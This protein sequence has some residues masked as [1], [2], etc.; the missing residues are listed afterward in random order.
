MEAALLEVLSGECAS[1]RLFR[2]E[3]PGGAHLLFR[4][5]VEAGPFPQPCLSLLPSS[6][7][8]LTSVA[9]SNGVQFPEGPH[10]GIRG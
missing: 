2:T 6:G 8:K 4:A 7:S 10:L 3:P 1:T 5:C 9:F